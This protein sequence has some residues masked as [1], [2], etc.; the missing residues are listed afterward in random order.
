MYIH[1]VCDLELASFRALHLLIIVNAAVLFDCG[2]CCFF[3]HGIN[4]IRII[5]KR[6]RKREINSM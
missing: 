4:K 6:E 2:R 3:V 5:K 1:S